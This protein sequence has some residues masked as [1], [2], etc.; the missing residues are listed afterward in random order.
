MAIEYSLKTEK[1]MTES[2]LLQVL[3]SMG[4]KD[5]DVIKLPRGIEIG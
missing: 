1:R 3:E 2:F 5:N 4:Y